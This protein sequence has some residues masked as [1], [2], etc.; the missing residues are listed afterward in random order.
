MQVSVDKQ[1]LYKMI[2]SAVKE[3]IKE[4]EFF[5]YLKN[6]APVSEKE[7]KDIQKKYGDPSSKHSTEYSETIEI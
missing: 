5:Y 7:M 3:V 4:E 1:E 6:L 2:K